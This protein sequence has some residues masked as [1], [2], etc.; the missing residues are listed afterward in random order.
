MYFLKE[1]FAQKKFVSAGEEKQAARGKYKIFK[2]A[3]TNIFS[4]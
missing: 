4:T 1:K 3:K 2:L